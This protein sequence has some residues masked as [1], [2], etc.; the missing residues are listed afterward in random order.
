MVERP[1]AP[2]LLASLLALLVL[3]ML[4]APASAKRRSCPKLCRVPIK[5]CKAQCTGTKNEHAACRLA[6]K[7]VYNQVCHEHTAPSCTPPVLACGATPL[8]CT[9]I[10]INFAN[11]RPN[12]GSGLPGDF[13]P[14]PAGSMLCGSVL[15]STDTGQP[16]LAAYLSTDDPNTVIAQYSSG[17][18]AS[19]YTFTEAESA[20][21]PTRTACDRAF[22]VTRD[23]IT[24]GGLYYF[25]AQ[26]AYFVLS[27]NA[28]AP[29][30]K[31]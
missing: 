2:R 18:V 11:W 3:A 16:P 1:L 4:S 29:P 27:G 24:V 17:F 8:T 20:L 9:L 31:R 7:L 26:S 19:G 22:R 10:A 12:D 30:T 6:C 23:G 13:P 15:G 14:A 21:D 5:Q 28:V 25:A